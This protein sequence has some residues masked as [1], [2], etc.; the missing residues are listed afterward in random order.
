MPQETLPATLEPASVIEPRAAVAQAASAPLAP[1]THIRRFNYSSS[2]V[3]F[4]VPPGVTTVNARCWGG[5]GH[6]AGLG[7]GGGFVA[8]D[9]AVVPGETLRVVVT[10]G[11]AGNGGGMSGLFS[12]RLGKPL[13]IAGGGGA[14]ISYVGNAYGGAGGGISGSDGQTHSGGGWTGTPARGASGATGGAGTVAPPGGYSGGRGGNSGHNGSNAPSGLGIGGKVPIGD[15]GGGGGG[16]QGGMGG[17]AGY[18]GG[19]GGAAFGTKT[20]WFASG[21]GG[22]SSF[23]NGPG[24]TNG[25]NLPGNGTRA[26]GKDDPLYQAP[27]GD[28]AKG[29]QVVLQWTEFT[30]TPGGPPD[31]ELRQGGG[32]G[33]PG[34]HVEAGVAFDPVSV[35]VAL[36]TSHDLL[37]GTQTLADYQ[38]TVQNADGNTAQ[39]TGSLSEDGTSLTFSDVDLQL[40]GTT[41]M[42]VAVSAGHQAPLGAG[43]LTFTVGGKPSPS[44]TVIVTPGFTVSPGGDPVT[45][46]REGAPVYP[47]VEVQNSGT[48]FIALQTVTATLPADT[49]LRFGTAAGPDHQ[50]TVWQADG[51]HSVYV[52]VLSA[53]GRTLT[54]PDVDLGVPEAGS[55]SVMWVCVTASDDTPTGPTTVA[56]A[57]G[58]RTSPSTTIQVI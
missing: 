33:Y 2:A 13:L 43:S 57:I 24:V 4:T 11:S 52:G 25:R 21:G 47:G 18:A 15:M 12:Q 46:E 41:V 50:L 31:V 55:Q 6:G 51:S 8:G 49:A 3:D 22:G 58:D 20:V 54:F 16:G 39:Y 7:G 29:G 28:A 26:G 40:P 53:D 37:F 35:A 9:I 5:G 14:G 48:E 36:P 45:A 10:L 23:V 30:V 32:P 27:V 19:G 17:G 34:V 44:T 42:W 1:Y 56:F 38:L